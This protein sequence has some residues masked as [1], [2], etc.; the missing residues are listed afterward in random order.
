MEPKEEKIEIPIPKK[1][2]GRKPKIPKPDT[3]KLTIEYGQFVLSFD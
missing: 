3:K 2:R 1:K